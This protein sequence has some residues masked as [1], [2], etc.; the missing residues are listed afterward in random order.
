MKSDEI[1]DVIKRFVLTAIPSVP[2]LEALLL[3]QSSPDVHWDGK[4]LASRLY[5]SERAGVSVLAELHAAGFVT[6]DDTGAY[7]Y[8][9]RSEEMDAMVI[10]VR[11]AYERNLVS[12]SKLIHANAST[13]AQQFADAFIFRKE[14]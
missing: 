2:F 3:L 14:V 6:R 12:I 10:A 4:S 11:D 7:C 13:Q 8:R 5:L 9:P 1:P